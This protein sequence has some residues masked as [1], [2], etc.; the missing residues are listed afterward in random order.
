MAW[1]IGKGEVKR[2]GRR[3]KR[4]NFVVRKRTIVPYGKELPLGGVK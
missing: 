2:T 1:R 4:S 3:R